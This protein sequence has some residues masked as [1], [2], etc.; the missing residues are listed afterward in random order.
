MQIR[1]LI[2]DAN[3]E[4]ELNFVVII[5]ELTIYDKVSDIIGV[6]RMKKI[7]GVFKPHEMRQARRRRMKNIQFGIF[8]NWEG[9]I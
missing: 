1:S 8:I 9:V 3:Y 2:S 4:L 5:V 6:F 7:V